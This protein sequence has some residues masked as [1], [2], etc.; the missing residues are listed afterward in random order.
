MDNESDAV[1]DLLC[2]IS[3]ET[4]CE[5]QSMLS[6]DVIFNSMVQNLLNDIEDIKN[7]KM[8]K[9][10]DNK[11]SVEIMKTLKSAEKMEIFNQLVKNAI[12][13]T[14]EQKECAEQLAIVAERQKIYAAKLANIA[15]MQNKDILTL[16]K[17]AESIEKTLRNSI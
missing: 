7:F 13:T 3:G 8:S 17:L 1:I 6:E 2:N 9:D 14:D 5:V 12:A 10:C 4:I 11:M 16:E 15:E